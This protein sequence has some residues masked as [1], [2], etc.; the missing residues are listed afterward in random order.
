MNVTASLEYATTLMGV[1]TVPVRLDS[2]ETESYVIVC[3]SQST[4][5]YH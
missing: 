3:H 1:I 2:L 4:A 5:C